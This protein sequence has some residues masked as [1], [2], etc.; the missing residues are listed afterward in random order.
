MAGKGAASASEPIV[1][2]DHSDIRAGS[3][4]ELR[5]GVKRLVD[6]IDQREPQ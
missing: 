4:D 6:F 2:I 1:Y 5:A 3:L